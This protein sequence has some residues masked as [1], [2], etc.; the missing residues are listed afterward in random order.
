MYYIDYKKFL[1]YVLE[2]LAVAISAYVI[3][4]KTRYYSFLEILVI[5]LTAAAVYAILDNFTPKISSGTRRGSG[6]GIGWNLV[7]R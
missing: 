2:G 3:L 1:K 7:G 4:G 6:F 5:G